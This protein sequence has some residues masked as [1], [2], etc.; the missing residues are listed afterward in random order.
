[1]NKVLGASLA[2]LWKTTTADSIGLEI[3][4]FPTG[5]DVFLTL[6]KGRSGG[7]FGGDDGFK[8]NFDRPI[9]GK[10]GVVPPQ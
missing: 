10:V 9:D 7:I 4:G 8:A 5:S 3:V 2:M 1:V 6:G